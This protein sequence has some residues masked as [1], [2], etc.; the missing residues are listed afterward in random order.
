LR[1]AW[2]QDSQ[3]YTEKPCLEKQNKTT[4]T[5]TTKQNKEA[6]SKIQ[7]QSG[8][9]LFRVVS[10]AV[11]ELSHLESD[12]SPGIVPAEAKLPEQ[13]LGVWNYPS[14]PSDL[15]VLSVMNSKGWCEV[16]H[17][18][19]LKQACSACLWQWGQ[20]TWGALG[21]ATP[22]TGILLQAHQ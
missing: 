9:W 5:T 8:T 16:Q 12:W 20:A 4:T 7:G 6:E 10:R 1:P 18:Y 21:K 17:W 22:S 2:F 19:S 15:H 13:T 3:G 11:P 14:L